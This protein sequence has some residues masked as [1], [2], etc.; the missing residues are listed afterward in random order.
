MTIASS[1][2]TAIASGPFGWSQAPMDAGLH[3]FRDPAGWRGQRAVAPLPAPA[4]IG[5]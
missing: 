5:I 2:P 4:A 3:R 1:R